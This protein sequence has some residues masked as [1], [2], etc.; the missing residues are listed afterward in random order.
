MCLALSE[1]NKRKILSHI[2]VVWERQ[3]PCSKPFPEHKKVGQF[4]YHCYFPESQGKSKLNIVSNKLTVSYSK[5]KKSTENPSSRNQ[6][7]T[8]RRYGMFCYVAQEDIT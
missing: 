6:N 2:K 8:G 7:P 1:V 3:V 5:K 4:L